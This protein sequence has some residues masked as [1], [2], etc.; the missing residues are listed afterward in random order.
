MNMR[1]TIVRT[2]VLAG[3]GIGCGTVSF[4]NAQS[5]GDVARQ[6]EARRKTVAK[7][8]KVYTNDSLRREPAPTS[9]AAAPSPAAGQTATTPPV[10]P[11]EQA[12]APAPAAEAEKTVEPR[13]E[14]Y[15]R[16]RVT[17]ARD[18][19]ARSETLRD[20]LQSRINALTTDFVNRD[21]P[22]QRA[23]I[24]ADRQT[25]LAELDRVN[26]EMQ[27]Y[28]KAIGDTEDAARRAGAPPGWLR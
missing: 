2:V 17:A 9:G 10:Q 18:G 7:P 26:R 23:K 5:L 6:E 24:S 20:A 8:A 4:A 1:M 15:W 25:A 21:D 3:V 12:P 27:D 19:A 16:A 22:A 11:Q 13:T 14:K 28:T